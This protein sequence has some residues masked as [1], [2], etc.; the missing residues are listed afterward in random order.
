MM[1]DRME[2]I[3]LVEDLVRHG[4]GPGMTLHEAMEVFQKLVV[5]S[6]LIAEQS[7]AK[8]MRKLGVSQMGLWKMR[9][10]FGLP[11]G[12]RGGHRETPIPDDWRERLG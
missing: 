8:A 1:D 3:E 7:P 12:K 4:V 2:R 11:I 9:R 6:T 5:E 10:R